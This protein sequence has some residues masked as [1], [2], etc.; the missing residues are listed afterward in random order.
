MPKLLILQRRSA[1]DIVDDTERMLTKTQEHSF[2]TRQILHRPLV[3]KDRI[4]GGKGSNLVRLTDKDDA[5]RVEPKRVIDR[6]GEL[7]RVRSEGF[8]GYEVLL[9]E[10]AVGPTD[11]QTAQDAVNRV[12]DRRRARGPR[13]TGAV[14]RALRAGNNGGDPG[15]KPAEG[16][17]PADIGGSQTAI[18]NGDCVRGR[19]WN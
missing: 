8:I 1:T 19:R 13:R 15:V 2:R 7:T 11:F 3:S 9:D 4:V 5:V 18:G 14:D 10:G 12:L 17:A 16:N 6:T